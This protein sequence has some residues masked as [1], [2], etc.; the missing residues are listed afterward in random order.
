MKAH[1][2]Y[3]EDLAHML[4]V[5]RMACGFTQLAVAEALGVNRSTYSYYELGRASPDV[6]TLKV[7]GRIFNVPPEEFLYPERFR[8]EKPAHQRQCVPKTSMVELGAIGDLKEEEQCLLARY[9]A[10]EFAK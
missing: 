1:S 5:I 7:L 8:D 3:Y 9:R 10:G 6:A 4:R 2:T